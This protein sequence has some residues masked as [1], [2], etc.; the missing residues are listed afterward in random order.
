MESG[1]GDKTFHKT[2]H[3]IRITPLERR[4]E[5]KQAVESAEWLKSRY[6][7]RYGSSLPHL[8]RLPL[9]DIPSVP[10]RFLFL[11]FLFSSFFFPL[12]STRILFL[13]LVLGLTFEG[14]FECKIFRRVGEFVSILEI[15]FNDLN[16]TQKKFI[17][18]VKSMYRRN[19][20]KGRKFY[21]TFREFLPFSLFGKSGLPAFADSSTNTV[22]RTMV[23]NVSLKR[24]GKNPSF[25]GLK[26]YLRDS[27]RF[28]E[29]K[30][31][32]GKSLKIF[33]N[34][35]ESILFFRFSIFHH[36]PLESFSL[37]RERENRGIFS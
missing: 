12:C 34:M 37:S 14:K 6:S 21:N 27:W 36:H 29:E 31:F 19:D 30:L 20:D 22:V 3:R 16:I 4:R 11:P 15:I 35:R 2:R 23:W 26:L 10:R 24:E 18:R 9:A 7:E 28:F 33:K 8:T 13:L 1:G 32:P 5:S 25:P 17:F